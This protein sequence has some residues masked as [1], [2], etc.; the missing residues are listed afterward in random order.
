MNR[1]LSDIINF[2]KTLTLLIVEDEETVLKQL[3]KS[4]SAIFTNILTA[5]N[6]EEATEIYFDYHKK[7]E[8]FVDIIFT[9]L[10]L[11]IMD[12]LEFCERI[13][14]YN[15]KQIIIASSAYADVN[16]LQ[17][18]IDLGIYKF[19]PKPINFSSMFETIVKSLEKIKT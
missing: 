2:S 18:I 8:K 4:F 17:K 5:K 1:R 11:P 13:K 9:D 6:G 15:D 3:V 19:I 16:N 14:P 12:G 7:N 10:H